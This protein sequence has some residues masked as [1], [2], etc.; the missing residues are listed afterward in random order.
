MAGTT[1]I[2]RPEDYMPV[3]HASVLFKPTRFFTKNPSMDVPGTKD[4]YSTCLHSPTGTATGTTGTTRTE[5]TVMVRRRVAD[6]VFR[7]CNHAVLSYVLPYV[8]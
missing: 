3:K 8:P 6:T 5:R 4:V 7:T 1:H 2:P